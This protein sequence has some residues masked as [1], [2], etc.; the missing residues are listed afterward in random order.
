MFNEKLE[1]I[2]EQL[3]IMR[4]KVK[5]KAPHWRNE[6]AVKDCYS[7]LCVKMHM[8]HELYELTFEHSDTGLSMNLRK[9]AYLVARKQPTFGKNIIIT[10]N[11]DWTTG[12][13]IQA[14]LDRWQ[15]EG[16]FR[17]NKDN[18]LVCVSPVR[19]WTDSKI[20]CR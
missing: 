18:D 19:H 10:D 20:R 12:D 11:T 15:V 1:A 8:P 5:D 13:I 9:N 7:R 17:L 16:R 2:C 4:A 6:E 14:N 3:L